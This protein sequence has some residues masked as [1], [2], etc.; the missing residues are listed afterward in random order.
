MKQQHVPLLAAR[1]WVGLSLASV[2]GANLGDYFAHD[3]GLGHI[4]GLPILAAAFAV[5][6]IAERYDRAV[7]EAWYWLAIVVVRAAATNLGDFF[8]GDLKIP[9]P[10][11]MAGLI[12]LLIL[13]VAAIRQQRLRSGVDRS[14]ELLDANALYWIGML[15]AGTLGTVMG[16]YVSHNLRLGNLPASAALALP[17]VLLFV[18]GRR[19]VLWSLLFFWLTVVMIRA[20]GTVIGDYL[21][22]RH[23]LGLPLGTLVTGLA[24]VTVLLAWKGRRLPAASM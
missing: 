1:F 17:L 3:I 8:A 11:V 21:A 22:G 4:A 14:R 10:W 5:L 7:H 20:D 19:G 6:L 13:T 18:F 12:V 15:I 2:F 16:D 9:R 23:M 24:F